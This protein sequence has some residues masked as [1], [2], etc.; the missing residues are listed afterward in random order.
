SKLASLQEYQLSIVAPTPPSN[1]YDHAAASRGKTV[2][3][4]QAKG[5][6]CHVPPLFTEPGYPLHP[7]EGTRIHDF[8]AKPSPT[9]PDRTTPLK[10]RFVRMK[11]GFCHDGRFVTLDDVV[12][13]YDS[14]FKL[15]LTPEQKRDL[16]EYLKSL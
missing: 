11:G 5:V 14:R 15:G 12:A 2:F 10:W 4:S 7:P 13:H 3:E 16:V 9:N 6:R 8:Q 1:S